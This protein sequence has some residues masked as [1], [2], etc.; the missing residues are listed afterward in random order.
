M[1]V[2]VGFVVC[3]CRVSGSGGDPSVEMPDVEPVDV[4][5]RRGLDVGEPG[6]GSFRVDQFPFVEPVEAFDKGVIETVALG[7]DRCHDLVVPKTLRV[8]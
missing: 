5:E 3:R 1:T 6:P 4:G 8:P 7:S 2:V